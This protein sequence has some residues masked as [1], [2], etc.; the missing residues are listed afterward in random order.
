MFQ[1]TRTHY[2]NFVL[3]GRIK[4]ID[5]KYH[6]L[7]GLTKDEMIDLIYYK[8]EDQVADMCTKSLKSLIF[9]KLRKLLVV[10]TLDNPIY[11]RVFRSLLLLN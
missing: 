4:H 1:A 7:W 10:C 6:F 9:Q 8:S 11:V 5:V 3:H 2:K